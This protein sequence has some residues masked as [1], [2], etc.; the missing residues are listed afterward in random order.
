MNSLPVCFC[1]WCIVQAKNFAKTYKIKILCNSSDGSRHFSVVC[2]NA[3]PS[4][5][6][7]F[8][9]SGCALLWMLI[10]MLTKVVSDNLTI[11]TKCVQML[12]TSP[13][14]YVTYI[15]N[16]VASDIYMYFSTAEIQW[17]T[18]M[19]HYGA[20]TLPCRFRKLGCLAYKKYIIIFKWISKQCIVE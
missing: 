19:L 11:Y 12:Y 4:D 6:I 10:K 20:L 9:G 14:K 5:F 3:I 7:F 16:S 8:Y 18:C 15:V 2:N 13:T 17:L 1:M